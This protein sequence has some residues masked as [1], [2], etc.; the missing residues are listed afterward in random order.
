MSELIAS[1]P[2]PPLSPYPFQLELEEHLSKFYE[3]HSRETDNKKNIKAIIAKYSSA[4]KDDIALLWKK[5]GDKYG[6][7]TISKYVNGSYDFRSA[8]FAPALALDH[9][10]L[11]PPVRNAPILDNLAKCRHMVSFFLIELPLS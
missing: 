8:S 5:I 4:T 11:H 6:P 7:S 10:Y 9:E 1:S 3:E 2:S